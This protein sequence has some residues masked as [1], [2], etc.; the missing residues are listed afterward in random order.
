[1][2]LQTL[3][4]PPR[5]WTCLKM[6]S[7]LKFQ[8]RSSWL[9]GDD[10]RSDGY[11]IS[12]IFG[13]RIFISVHKSVC[14]MNA[15]SALILIVSRGRKLK[16][17]FYPMLPDFR[18]TIAFWK[19]SRLRPLVLLLRATFSRRWRWMWRIGGMI[20]ARA[21]VLVEEP[22]PL[23]LCGPKIPHGLAWDGTLSS[24]LEAGD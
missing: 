5:K 16:V 14:S 6:S 15:K 13:N 24:M 23:P 3:D 2:N 21:E 10:S 4:S 1:M 12:R 18:K 19:V 22:V 20:Q 11:E 7:K 17:L 8:P 9:S